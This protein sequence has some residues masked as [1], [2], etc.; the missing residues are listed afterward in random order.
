[1]TAPAYLTNS[2][3]PS[4]QVDTLYDTPAGGT[5]VPA[6]KLARGQTRTDADGN[7]YQAHAI[8]PS[9]GTLTDRSGTI[10]LG[11]TAQT[12]MAANASRVYLLIQNQDATEDLWI[13]FTTTAV[14]DEPSIRLPALSGFVME[15]GFVSTQAVS[16]IAA[17]TSHKWT[18]KEA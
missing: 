6:Y 15:T 16:V 12:M 17:T 11:G 7:V 14:E 10:T 5:A 9:P 1:M 13:N 8:A 3:V 4:N 2:N 18:A